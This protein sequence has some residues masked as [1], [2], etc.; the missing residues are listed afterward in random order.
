MRK[1]KLL[2]LLLAVCMVISI[3]AVGC[4]TESTDETAQTT[5]SPEADSAA[6]AELTS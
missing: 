2:A 4:G 1:S 3:V 5:T 6:P